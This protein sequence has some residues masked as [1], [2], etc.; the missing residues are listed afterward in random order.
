[1]LLDI[2]MHTVA[3]SEEALPDQCEIS[4]VKFLSPARPGDELIIHWGS[5]R[6]GTIRFDIAAGARKVASGTMAVKNR[7]GSAESAEC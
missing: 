3:A 7:A 4:A 1:M 2:V 6:D 5:L